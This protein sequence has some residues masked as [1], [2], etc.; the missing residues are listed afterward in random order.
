MT[1]EDE[2]TKVLKANFGLDPE[3]SLKVRGQVAS[4]LVAWQTAKTRI[5]M[6]AEAEGTSELREWAKPIPQTDYVAMRQAYAKSY[7]ELEDK[8]IPSK[9][10]LEKKLHELENGKFRAEALTEVVSRDEVDPDTLMP[11]WDA[12]GHITVKRGNTTV[13][14][15]TGPEQLR[16][17]LTVMANTLIMMR[18]KHTARNELKDITPAFFEKYKDYLLGDYVY[19]LRASDD[20][21]GMIPPWTLVLS[22]EHAIRKHCYFK[23]ALEKSWKDATVKERHFTTPL[24]LYAKRGYTATSTATPDATTGKGNK[25]KGKGKFKGKKGHARIPANKPIC[26]RYNSKGGCKKKLNAISS[27]YVRYALATI[28]LPSARRRMQEIPRARLTDTT[29]KSSRNQYL[30]LQTRCLPCYISLQASHDLE[31]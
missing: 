19:G 23:L 1:S 11:V 25:G 16:M 15:P 3:A 8:Q 13:A 24:A 10:Y 27:T 2:L 5:K 12:K 4:Y 21:G 20:Y 9:E 29:R 7:G 22:Y 6:Q 26:F 18:M 14:M 31:I 28:L 17:R 30:L